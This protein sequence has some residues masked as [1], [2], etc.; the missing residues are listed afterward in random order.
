MQDGDV[1]AG[2]SLPIS[3]GNR[4][5]GGEEVC[6]RDSQLIS[7]EPRGH[8]SAEE[9]GEEKEGRRKEKRGMERR[10]KGREGLQ[11]VVQPLLKID[12]KRKALSS[13]YSL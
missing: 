4:A 11:E 12:I 3:H 10:E 8:S 9:R 5:S 1:D 6:S 2:G 7:R 13:I